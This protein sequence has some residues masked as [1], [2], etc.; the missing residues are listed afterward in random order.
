MRYERLTNV[1][2]KFDGRGNLILLGHYRWD[3]KLA[4]AT[5]AQLRAIA[6]GNDKA[7]WNSYQAWAARDELDRR[8][9]RTASWCVDVEKGWQPV[10]G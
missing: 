7:D 9:P 6:N 2:R 5:L 3:P 8:A 10:V 1:P 4:G